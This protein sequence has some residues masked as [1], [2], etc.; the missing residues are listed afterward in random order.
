MRSKWNI[1][2][3]RQAAIERASGRAIFRLCPTAQRQS[4]PSSR[5]PPKPPFDGAKP[6]QCSVYYFWWRYLRE[7]RSLYAV[8]P[9]SGG[10]GK[11]AKLYRDF[12]DVRGDD[13]WAWWKAH[14]HLFSE[15]PANHTKVVEER[16]AVKSRRLR[17]RSQF[18]LDIPVVVGNAADQATAASFNEAPRKA[19]DRQQGSISSR[20]QACLEQPSH[21]F[22]GLGRS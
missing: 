20:D 16:Q 14:Q 15:P 6:W 3:L 21:S 5:K 11:F 7:Q 12:G 9:S 2:A 18:R 10:R 13:F 1:T 4:A 22:A 8:L 17:D 19:D